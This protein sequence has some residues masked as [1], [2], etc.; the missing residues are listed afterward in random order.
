MDLFTPLTTF[1]IEREEKTGV[2]AAN[3]TV[4]VNP[5]LR[6]NPVYGFD[7]HIDRFRIVMRITQT[8]RRFDVSLLGGRFLRD[9]VVGFDFSG[10][11][12]EPAFEGGDL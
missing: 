3:L 8:V 9:A 5:A 10:D 7:P 6:V 2:T 12:E 11:F 1:A 4:S